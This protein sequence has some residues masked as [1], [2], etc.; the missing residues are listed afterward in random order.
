MPLGNYKCLNNF[1]KF[2]R[3]TNLNV[4]YPQNED[5]NVPKKTPKPN[6]GIYMILCK[7]KNNWRYYGETNTLLSRIIKH[8]GDLS[9]GRSENR[10]LQKD[11]N[12]F[13][14]DVFEFLILFQR[15]EWENVSFRRE[16]ETQQ[17]I[18]ENRDFGYNLFESFNARTGSKNPFFEK[19]H[20]QKNR[21][22]FET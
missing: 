2:I 18:I 11:Y 5:N 16:K 7:K 15:I 21:S 14:L 12:Q 1:K 13:G 19:T 9:F 4:K 3:K 20:T 6:P 10:E 8:K 22:V 17:L